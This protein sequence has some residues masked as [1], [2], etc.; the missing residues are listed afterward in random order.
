M[1]R[2]R[3]CFS[4]LRFATVA[5]SGEEGST[6]R[7]L[8]LEETLQTP[9]ATKAAKSVRGSPVLLAFARA[10]NELRRELREGGSLYDVRTEGKGVVKYMRRCSNGGSL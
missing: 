3:K 7:P 10:R 1:L 5:S 4:Q 9:I 8:A 2:D 6:T